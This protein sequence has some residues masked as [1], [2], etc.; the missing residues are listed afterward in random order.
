MSN[1]RSAVPSAYNTISS[2]RS[3]GYSMT[4]AVADIIDNSIS[5]DAKNITLYAPSLDDPILLIVDDGHGMDWNELDVA[6]TFGGAINCQEIRDKNDLGRFGMGLKTASLSQCTCLEV[7]S[8]KNG[9]FVGGCWNLAYIKKNDSWD[10]LVIS[11][12]DCLSKVKGT[13]LASDSVPSGTAVIWSHFDRLRESAVNK[14]DE[15][16]NQMSK[17]CEMLSLIFHRYMTGETGINKVKITYNGNVLKPNDPF[18]TGE[19]AELAK[20]QIIPLNNEIIKV[21]CHKLPHPD[22]LTKE[23][24]RRVQL[25][26][27]LLETQGFY[28]YRNKRLIDYGTWFG[29]AS[30]LDKTK[31]S[32]IQID[33]PNTLD[34]VWSLD[35]KK[36]KAIP[37][38]KI[39]DD[40]RNILGANADKSKR[41]YT[42]RA[43][44]KDSGSYWIREI[45]PTNSIEY[46]VNDEHPLIK[47]FKSRLPE[48]LVPEFDLVLR[49]VSKY[50]PFSQL[51]LDQQDDKIIENEMDSYQQVG[52]SDDV[53]MMLALGFSAD[54]ILKT[55]PGRG[56]D[57]SR[58]LKEI[59]GM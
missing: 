49:N 6:M 19:I 52:L 53:Q 43:R 45:T 8:K 20:E 38:E 46:S 31:L 24:L 9:V 54:D 26:S 29:L 36:S 42:T 51:E 39:R 33:I 35:I 50:F 56:E 25:G 57:V 21:H 13:F 55:Y 44:K 40:L 37:P 32:R 17:T 23:Q 7:I 22:K 34:S 11:E 3:I 58:I 15:F 5:A 59:G 12:N 16:S 10:Y 27:T 28:V 41:T 18:L 47:E 1:T 4:S 14:F 48:S 2:N 30:K